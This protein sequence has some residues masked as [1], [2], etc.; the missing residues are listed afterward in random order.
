MC[1]V[2][3]PSSITPPPLTF[4]PRTVDI[5]GETVFPPLPAPLPT[6]K[7]GTIR[8]VRER[9]PVKERRRL[10]A[11]STCPLNSPVSRRMSNILQGLLVARLPQAETALII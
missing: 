6:V 1:C 5:T 8:L 10:R 4:T 2:V 3:P 9:L 7:W 11:C